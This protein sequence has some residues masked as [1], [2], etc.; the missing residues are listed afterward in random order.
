MALGDFIGDPAFTADRDMT[1][2]S[3]ESR[4]DDDAEQRRWVRHIVERDVEEGAFG[5]LGLTGEDADVV[6]GRAPDDEPPY[7][8]LIE[9]LEPTVESWNPVLGRW[10]PFSG[11]PR[12]PGG[13]QAR[14]DRSEGEE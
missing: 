7:E 10:V 13:T 6:Y 9:D 14:R 2:G 5:R 1:N 8:R 12:Q 4:R 11:P 3:D